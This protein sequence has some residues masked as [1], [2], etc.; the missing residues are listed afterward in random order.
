MEHLAIKRNEVLRH[1]IAGESCLGTEEIG[2][3]AVVR[4][5]YVRVLTID[6]ESK[7]GRGP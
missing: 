2:N 6:L 5:A 1:G 7:D 4:L 3:W